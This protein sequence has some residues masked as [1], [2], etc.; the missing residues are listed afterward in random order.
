MG[1]KTFYKIFN[2]LYGI[3]HSYGLKPQADIYSAISETIL[4]RCDLLC[5]TDGLPELVP[6]WED[7]TNLAVYKKEFGITPIVYDK[8]ETAEGKRIPL[9]NFD[10]DFYGYFFI[11]PLSSNNV[12]PINGEIGDKYQLTYDNGFKLITDAVEVET[13][14]NDAV[15][16]INI[17]IEKLKEEKKNIDN[18][19]PGQKEEDRLF[20]KKELM[21]LEILLENTFI[22]IKIEQKKDLRDELIHGQITFKVGQMKKNLEGKQKIKK[23]EL[24]SAK[25]N[26]QKH[27]DDIY[28]SITPAQYNKSKNEMQQSIDN[29]QTGIDA[30]ELFQKNI[31]AYK[32]RSESKGT[33]DEQISDLE[34]QKD[35]LTEKKNKLE[36]NVDEKNETEDEDQPD[37]PI[38]GFNI[39]KEDVNGIMYYMFS[40]KEYLESNIPEIKF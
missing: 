25:N 36:S 4:K 19:T 9:E 8:L 20:L 28:S 38:T 10:S 6:K 22:G 13:D 15:N 33:L 29:T 14:E 40:V 26:Y 31:T 35:E 7:K 21:L 18:P 3:L 30:F 24:R 37:D 5:N 16:E 39:K 32:K 2:E 1:D 11:M 23:A 27:M 12:N 34:K 17:K